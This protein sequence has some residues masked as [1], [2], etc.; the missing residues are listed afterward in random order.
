MGKKNT[1]VMTSS[2]DVRKR[3]AIVVEP[4]PDKSIE[5]LTKEIASMQAELDRKIS[6]SEYDFMVNRNN[7]RTIKQLLRIALRN[8]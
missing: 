6:S 3:A 4:T 8:S 1:R 2:V 5:E 7:Q